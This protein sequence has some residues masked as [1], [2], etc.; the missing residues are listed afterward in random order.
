[1]TP[2]FFRK[3][4]ASFFEKKVFSYDTGE[5]NDFVKRWF[6]IIL[7]RLLS[8]HYKDTWLLIIRPVFWIDALLLYPMTPSFFNIW[9]LSFSLKL[10]ASFLEEKMVSY[11]AG[12]NFLSNVSQRMTTNSMTNLFVDRSQ[13]HTIDWKFLQ[14][15]Q[16]YSLQNRYKFYEA[17]FKRKAFLSGAAEHIHYKQHM[18]WWGL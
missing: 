15:Q 4:L 9:S 11:D 1:M 5:N 14:L 8:V 18:L 2:T 6:R 13:Y 7:E 16:S 3:M 10:I 17:I 12:E